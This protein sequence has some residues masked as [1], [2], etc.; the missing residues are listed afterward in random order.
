MGN[1]NSD[2]LSFID[3]LITNLEKE[4][5]MNEEQRE[6]YK[7]LIIERENLLNPGYKGTYIPIFSAVAH[8]LIKYGEDLFK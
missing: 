3:Y 7:K 5:S 2:K 4:P 8:L 6:M 1:N